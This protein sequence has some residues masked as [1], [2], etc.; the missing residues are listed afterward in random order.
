MEDTAERKSDFTIR[1]PKEYLHDVMRTMH[2]AGRGHLFLAVHEGTR[3][4]GVFV[5]TFGQKSWFMH[6]ASSIEKRTHNP[7]HLLQWEVMRWAKKQ[8]INY[9]DMVGIPKPGNRN[10]DDP[11][12]PLYYKVEHVVF[13]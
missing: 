9:Y 6:G 12:Y 8:G 3:L 2:D 4:A 7:Y 11:Y 10:E 13:Y 1:R 5:F